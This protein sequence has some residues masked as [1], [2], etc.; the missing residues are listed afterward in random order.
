MRRTLIGLAA[1]TLLGV[2]ACSDSDSGGEAAGNNGSSEAFCEE[3]QAL[4]ERFTQD[5]EAASD[6]A[7]AIAALED[8]D[9]PDEIAG[10][11]DALVGASSL[12]PSNP[13]DAAELEERN[14]EL[15]DAK[16]KVETFLV[17]E[18]GLGGETTESE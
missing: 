6:P 2:T 11:F 15:V 5:P 16:E 4:E 9:P 7:Q 10:E 1:I 13:D 3:Y 17:D 14:D 12:D 8:L 18:C